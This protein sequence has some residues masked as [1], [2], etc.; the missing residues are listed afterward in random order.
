MCG[1]SWVSN[2][3]FRAGT[4][5]FSITQTGFTSGA[6]RKQ[7]SLHSP[8]CLEALKWTKTYL[9]ERKRVGQL[10]KCTLLRGFNQRRVH[11]ATVLLMVSKAFGS[12]S[13]GRCMCTQ[14]MHTQIHIKEPT[15]GEDRWCVA[16]S[17]LLFNAGLQVGNK[18]ALF[19]SGINFRTGSILF[20][21]LYWSNAGQSHSIEHWEVKIQV[22]LWT[23]D[24]KVMPLWRKEKTRFLYYHLIDR[25]FFLF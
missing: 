10:P 23:H 18:G 24:V 7:P 17:G 2:N 13:T 9:V 19:L 12:V 15:V 5:L 25:S 14:H 8:G 6:R 1:G 22:E 21:V 11:W 3:H 4:N 16:C 20:L